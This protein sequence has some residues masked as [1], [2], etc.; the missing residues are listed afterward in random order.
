M[1]EVKFR[2]VKGDR[3]PS[4]QATLTW[5]DGSAVDLTNCTAK[6]HMKKGDTVKV[7]KDASIV[8]PPTDGIVQYDWE[9]GDTD[10]DGVWL[11]EFEI[12]F[13]DG[14]TCTWPTDADLKIIFRKPYDT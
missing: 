13:A 9:D 8:D 2:M 3:K 6:F 11:G 14:T 12:T 5:K 4:I 10:V 1:T 7:N